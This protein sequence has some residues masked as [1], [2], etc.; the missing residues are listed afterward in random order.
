MRYFLI[1]LSGCWSGLVLAWSLQVEQVPLRYLLQTLADIQGQNIVLSQNI[2]GKLDVHLNQVSWNQIWDFMIQTQHL[3]IQDSGGIL[4][5]DRTYRFL[6]KGSSIK[7]V[8]PTLQNKWFKLSH[9]EV[10]DI[11]QILMD[12]NQTCLS[13]VGKVLF[14][15]QVNG[16]WV[17]DVPEHLNQ[18]GDIIAKIDVP[19]RQIEIQA[20][21]VSINKNAAK[22]LGIRLG[23]TQPGIVSG[24]LAGLQTSSTE[25]GERLNVNLAAL[26]LEASPISYAVALAKLGQQY[27]DAELSLLEGKGQAQ[28][29]SRPRLVTQNQRESSISSGEDIPYQESSLNGAT[30]VA[31]KKALLKLKV[32]PYILG[33]QRLILELEINQDADSGRRVQGVPIIATKSMMTKVNIRNGET[34]VLGG[35]NKRDIHYEKVGMPVLK[36]I[37]GLGQLFSRE[38]ERHID[39][40]LILFITPKIQ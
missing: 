13:P 4:W 10:R 11:A 37:P 2:Q 7:N 9:V 1:L 6:E 26:P 19:R 14:D 30:S 20:R 34:L 40:E 18:V 24:Q 3:S 36:D 27:I 23:F 32:K 39:E 12:K 38:Q 21:I 5:V 15:E 31:F 16:L 29:I 22:D 35:I 25:P 28:I 8:M 33:N 17:S